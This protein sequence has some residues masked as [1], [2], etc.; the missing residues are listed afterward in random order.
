MPQKLNSKV[1]MAIGILVVLIGAFFIFMGAWALIDRVNDY[2]FTFDST[3]KFPLAAIGW[4]IILIAVILKK[5]FFP[6]KM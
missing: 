2:N 1:R 5:H 6:K 4:G 3:M